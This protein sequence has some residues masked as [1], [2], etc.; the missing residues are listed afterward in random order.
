MIFKL[1]FVYFIDQCD[2]DQFRCQSGIC[3]YKDNS[4]CS[5]PCIKRDWVGDGTEDCTD[6]SDECKYI[7]SFIRYDSTSDLS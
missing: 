7:F 6:G 1:I 5:G 4:N 3:N 2:D